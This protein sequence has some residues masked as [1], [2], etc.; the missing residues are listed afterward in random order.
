MNDFDRYLEY[1]LRRLLDPVVE[2]G[3]P[4]RWW[5]KDSGL[6][7]LSVMKAPIDRVAEVL[8]AVEP[9]AVPVPAIQAF[10]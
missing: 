9:V 3:A 1:E 5:P 10:R 2:A 4:R 7:L 6:P 8:P